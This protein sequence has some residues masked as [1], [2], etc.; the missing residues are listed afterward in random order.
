MPVMIPPWLA[1]SS[2]AGRARRP[3]SLTRRAHLK[4]TPPRA[5]ERYVCTRVSLWRGFVA[6]ALAA[7]FGFA[8][9]QN[10]GPRD[11]QV[12]PAPTVVEAPADADPHP[13]TTVI[14]VNSADRVDFDVQGV[15]LTVTLADAEAIK[16]AL[17][18]RLQQQ[19]DV[20]D[21]DY[22]IKVTQQLSS[23]IRDGSVRVAGWYLQVR[24]GKLQ[25]MFRMPAGPLSAPMYVAT[26]ERHEN[27]WVVVSILQGEILRR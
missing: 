20:E 17:I 11:T 8:G 12:G 13:N 5:C 4:T 22:L 1:H 10:A 25:L 6:L 7:Q 21:R 14:P 3:W 15:S 2:D 23:S 18:A 9:C 19:P 16:A 26:V 27:D 24:H